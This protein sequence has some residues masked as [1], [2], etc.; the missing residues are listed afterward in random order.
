MFVSDTQPVAWKSGAIPTSGRRPVAEALKSSFQ[1]AGWQTDIGDAPSNEDPTGIEIRGINSDFTRTVT[2]FL[3]DAGYSAAN[4]VITAT[5]LKP[6][7]EIWDQAN[8][9]ILI[10]VGY[11]GDDE[12][13]G[14]TYDAPRR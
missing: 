5:T 1:D 6:S 14:I 4:P 7:A 12:I 10:A 2:K 3:T 13:S 9:E 11:Y 8:Q